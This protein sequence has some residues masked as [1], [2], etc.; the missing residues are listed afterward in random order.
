M[1]TP[2]TPLLLATGL[3]VG[4]SLSSC[5]GTYDAYG[6][7]TTSTVTTYE[8]GYRLSTLPTGYR[9]ERISGSTYYYHDGAYYRPGDSGY[10]VVE[11]PRT[12][13]YY[14]DYDDYRRR[15][16]TQ[17]TT[18]R[19][20]DGRGS[21]VG[22]R[23]VITRLPSGYRTITHRGEQYYQHGDSYYQ[24]QGNGYIIASRPY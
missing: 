12:S 6:P 11:A 17:R 16:V 5:V 22:D 8:P 1:K 13:R 3:I 4:L 20:D 21:T 2:R 15:T 23:R 7:P 24:R 9:T 19:Y 10:V 18:R 14:S